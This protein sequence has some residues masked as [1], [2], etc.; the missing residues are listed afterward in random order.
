MQG[1]R[2][3]GDER[4]SRTLRRRLAVTMLER[5]GFETLQATD[6]QDGVD[7][8]RQNADKV[9]CVLLDLT[10]PRMDAGETFL[11]LKK[12][13]DDVPVVLCSGY[14][15]TDL[16]ERFDGYGMAGYVHKPYKLSKLRETLQ[17]VLDAEA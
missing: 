3:L 13:R 4:R 2:C 16:A 9:V 15:E 14:D 8:F 1:E 10:M 12:I 17:S 11:A 6:G 5:M 7:V